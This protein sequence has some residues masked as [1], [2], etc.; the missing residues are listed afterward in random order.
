MRPLGPTI[1]QG[2]RWIAGLQLPRNALYCPLSLGERDIVRL[3]FRLRL[4]RQETPEV[5]LDFGT[6]LPR[7][8]EELQ[9]LIVILPGSAPSESDAGDGV[10]GVDRR[11]NREACRCDGAPSLELRHCGS[12]VFICLGDVRT[13][14]ARGHGSRAHLLRQRHSPGG[15]RVTDRVRPRRHA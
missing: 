2:T 10:G 3:V 11:V 8:L 1:S 9:R 13:Y 15:R 4:E 7:L 6:V 5:A 12:Q 14:V